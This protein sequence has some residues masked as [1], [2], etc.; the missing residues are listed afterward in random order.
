MQPSIIPPRPVPSFLP[1]AIRDRVAG[2]Q[3][4]FSLPR[5][6]K[7]RMRTPERITISQWAEKYRR[8]TEIDAHPGPWRG[9]LVPHTKK[10]MDTIGLPHVRE[11]WMCMVERAAKTQVL[12]NATCHTID[13]GAKSGNIFWL[14]PTQE[15]S[16]QAVGERL[17]PVLR[18]CGPT[19]RL[20]SKN[21]D[22]TSRG[23]IRFKHGLRL[24]PA[25]SNSPGSMAS[26]FGR[27]N[28]GDEI[29][30]FAE[31]TSEGTDPITLFKKRSRDDIRGSKYLFASTPAGRYIYKGM[32]ACQQ[33]Y[34][35]QLRCPH[36]GQLIT[37]ALD[38]LVIP[39]GA[40]VDSVLQLDIRYACNACNH[41]FNEA[42]RE[43]AYQHGAWLCIKGADI[44]QPESVGFH[45]PALP[46]PKVPM[47][48]IAQK[49]LAAKSGD[50]A[51][52]T[53]LAN[54]YEAVDYEEEHQSR[55][56]DHILRLVD[57]GMPR[58]TVPTDV[59]ALLMFV[60]TQRHGY[61]YEI[62]AYSWGREMES[63]RID[64]GFVEAEEHLVDISQ[65]EF[66]DATGKGYRLEAGFIDSGGGTDPSNPKHSRTVAVY[67]FCRRYR[68]FRPLKGV[69]TQDQPWTMIR[70]DFY[71]SRT[72][73]KIPIPGGLILYKINVN[74]YKDALD[75][76]LMIEPHDPGSIHFHAGF[77]EDVA[78]QLCV[79]YRDERGKWHCPQGKDNHHWDINVYAMAGADIQGIGNRRRETKTA[80]R[81]VLSKGVQQQ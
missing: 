2:Q 47:T 34:S 36:C 20:L 57:H 68:F 59:N 24:R 43:N 37:M 27:L 78:K 56:V 17:I 29:D 66:F 25:W 46:C 18:A 35:Y 4:S 77:G 76:K 39:E 69:A 41:H 33:V 10:I 48:E 15:D 30:K 73:K 11:V 38:R 58:A 51:A 81:R 79:E 42:D 8:V 70:R 55:K 53:A 1:P 13:Q 26:Y 19:N 5:Q 45:F 61:H 71:P 65:R 12:I 9:D 74:F 75:E 80:Q 72:G 63:W 3:Y 62:V 21:S 44:K 50:L 54:G 67:E 6:V 40:D 23:I 7:A 60:D 31:R 52:K 49:V 28:I 22:D 14:M 16:R 64:H 32:L